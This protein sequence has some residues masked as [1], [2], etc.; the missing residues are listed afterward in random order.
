MDDVLTAMATR[1]K[2]TGMTWEKAPQDVGLSGA[3]TLVPAG[4]YTTK[5][6]VTALFRS[7]IALPMPVMVQD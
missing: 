4:S 7:S 2:S 6:T 3:D 1:Q 5:L